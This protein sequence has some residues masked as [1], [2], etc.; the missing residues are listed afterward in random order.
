MNEA[1]DGAAAAAAA[2]G[3]KGATIAHLEGLVGL[4]FPGLCLIAL[5]A[6]DTRPFT[7][8]HSSPIPQLAICTLK[9]VHCNPDWTLKKDTP[10]DALQHRKSALDER[11]PGPAP[12]GAGPDQSCQVRWFAGTL[13][14]PTCGPSLIDLGSSLDAI[15]S[16][17]RTNAPV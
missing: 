13:H 3:R 16:G 14:S 17:L 11:R 12:R 10:G 2:V 9:H 15:G 5:E 1:G 8:S 4:M 7:S 6:R